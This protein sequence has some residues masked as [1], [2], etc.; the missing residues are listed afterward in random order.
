M[1]L[2]GRLGSGFKGKHR[3][4]ARAFLVAVNEYWLSRILVAYASRH[5]VPRV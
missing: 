5:T 4:D 3:F 1:T 2:V